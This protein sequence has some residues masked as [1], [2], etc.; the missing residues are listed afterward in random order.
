MIYAEKYGGI[1]QGTDDNTILSTKDD[2]CMVD[3]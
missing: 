2:I 3:K 1:R